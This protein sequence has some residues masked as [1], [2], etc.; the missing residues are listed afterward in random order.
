MDFFGQNRNLDLARISVPRNPTLADTMYERVIE[1]IADFE[2]ELDQNHEVGARLTNLGTTFTVAIES[3]GYHNPYLFKIHGLTQ[4]G[5]RCTL[6]QHVSQLN[7]LLVAIPA[8]HKPARRV[9]PRGEFRIL[10]RAS[11]R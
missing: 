5:N 8:V 4:D 2:R 9:P 11:A 10:G 6:L 7:I 3:V 1:A